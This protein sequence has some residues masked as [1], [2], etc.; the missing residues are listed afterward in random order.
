MIFTVNCTLEMKHWHM[1]K[2]MQIFTHW[3]TMLILIYNS[4]FRFIDKAAEA[5]V[6]LHSWQQLT[7]LW[8]IYLSE[9]CGT[10]NR[11]ILGEFMTTTTTTTTTWLNAPLFEEL[12]RG[13]NFDWFVVARLS[14][15]L[16][17]PG[18]LRW[19]SKPFLCYYTSQYCRLTVIMH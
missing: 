6:C 11:L 14:H 15:P 13:S 1:D 9:Y 5:V 19:H 12:Q 2:I 16:R 18:C 3:E 4:C 8:V 17:S 7:S 10:M